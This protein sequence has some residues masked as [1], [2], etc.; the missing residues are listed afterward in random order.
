MVHLVAVY[1]LTGRPLG[2]GKI[3]IL[4]GFFNPLVPGRDIEGP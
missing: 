4:A 2:L 1:G 3:T